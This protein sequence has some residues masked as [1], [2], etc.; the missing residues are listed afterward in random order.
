MGDGAQVVYHLVGSHT[1]TAVADGERTGVL[2]R[3]Q[4]DGQLDIGIE[5][6]AVGEQLEIETRQRVGQRS[7]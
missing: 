5:H 1:N 6:L 4:A 2:I 3:Q 7:R